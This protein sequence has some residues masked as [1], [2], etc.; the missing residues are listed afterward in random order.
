M[1]ELLDAKDDCFT[2]GLLSKI[3]SYEFG[4]MQSTKH[5]RK[6]IINN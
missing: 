2:L 4:N 1:L 6:V 5:R 3:V